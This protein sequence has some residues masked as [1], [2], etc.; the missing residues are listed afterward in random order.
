MDPSDTSDLYDLIVER[1]RVASTVVTTNRERPG[2]WLAAMADPLL[3]QSAVD[4]LLSN[5]WQ[6]VVEGPSY[7]TRQRPGR[8]PSENPPPPPPSRRKRRTTG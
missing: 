4:R 3:A 5:A 1:H 2:E 8:P 6:L 7:R